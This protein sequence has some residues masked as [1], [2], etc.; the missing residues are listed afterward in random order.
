MGAWRHSVQLGI[1]SGLWSQV[2]AD[3]MVHS[4]EQAGREGDDQVLQKAVL[5]TEL[6]I[7]IRSRQVGRLRFL[8]FSFPLLSS[9]FITLGI[10]LTLIPR[11]I[12]SFLYVDDR[13]KPS[14]N[15]GGMY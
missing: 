12:S 10:I 9:L 2:P 13:I 7:W 8:L 6:K 11:G 5:V 15:V 3:S 14:D 1:T 4:S